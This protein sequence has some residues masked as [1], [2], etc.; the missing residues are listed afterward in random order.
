MEGRGELGV[1]RIGPFLTTETA[2][3][4][5]HQQAGGGVADYIRLLPGTPHCG[6]ALRATHP[7]MKGCD[8]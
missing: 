7:S 4:S 3:S 2:F 8:H 6:K 5:I 1:N